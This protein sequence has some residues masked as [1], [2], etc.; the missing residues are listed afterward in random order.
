[1]FSLAYTLNQFLKQCLKR[2]KKMFEKAVC[3]F[4]NII[5][6]K[7]RLN[8]NLQD[9]KRKEKGMEIYRKQTEHVIRTRPKPKSFECS[10]DVKCKL[11]NNSRR[12]DGWLL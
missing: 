4:H 1:M 11:G 8:Y 3:E 5:F 6:D 2:L 7:E 9:H 10:S 12:C